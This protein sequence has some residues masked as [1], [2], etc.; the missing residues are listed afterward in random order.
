M[1]GELRGFTCMD[2]VGDPS[3][4]RIINCGGYDTARRGDGFKPV[5]GVVIVFSRG[6]D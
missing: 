5:E 6:R 1:I 2:S 4:H 3:G